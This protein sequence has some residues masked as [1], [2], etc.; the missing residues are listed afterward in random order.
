[1]EPGR[2]D[3]ASNGAITWNGDM[4]VGEPYDPSVQPGTAAYKA[5]RNLDQLVEALK[6]LK[7]QAVA[8]DTEPIVMVNGA[9]T[10]AHQR[11]VDVMA[12]L[13]EADIHSVGLS[14]T[15]DE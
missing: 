3:V 8:V 14:T 5:Q 1:V 2:I 13:S 11:I 4:P 12:A 7:E 15:A 10:A 9:P 6:T